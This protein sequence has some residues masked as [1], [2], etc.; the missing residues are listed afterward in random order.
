M[1]QFKF[2]LGSA[3]IYVLRSSSNDDAVDLV[4]LGTDHSVEIL[5][6]GEHAAKVH[7]LFAS[8]RATH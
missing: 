2:D 1:N 3:E 8:L 5:L 7:L 4:A 6:I